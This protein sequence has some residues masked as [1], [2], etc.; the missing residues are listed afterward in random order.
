MISRDGSQ[1]GTLKT[2]ADH[3]VN[4]LLPLENAFRNT[5]AFRMLLYE[6]GWNVQGL[7]PSYV[8]VSDAVSKAAAAL[9]EL[10]DG[11]DITKIFDVINAARTVY[12]TIRDLNEAPGGVDAAVFLPELSDRLFEYLLSH[13]L[14][15]QAPQWFSVL[16][17]FGI[18]SLEDNPPAGARPGFTRVRFDWA[19]IPATLADPAS[20]PARVFNWGGAE[21]LVIA[22]LEVL[23]ELAISLGLSTSQDL[24]SDGEA[25]TFQD[26]ATGPVER[27]ARTAMTVTLFNISAPDNA[28]VDVGATFAELPPEGD[29]PVGLV[30][31]PAVPDGIASRT[32]FGNG[33][34]FTVRAVTELGLDFSFVL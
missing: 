20:I 3:L 15:Q 10:T 29:A 7:P 30:V 6:L 19:A 14:L 13:Y 33:W 28:Q 23:E 18:I 24:L 32:D 8:T 9:A 22:L 12:D 21:V 25:A 4:A 27:T 26:A 17:L 1:Q 11:A 31:M 5:E 34:A 2:F 16:E